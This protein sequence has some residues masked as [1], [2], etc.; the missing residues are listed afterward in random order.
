MRREINWPENP[1][2][3]KSYMHNQDILLSDGSIQFALFIKSKS[4]RTWHN[5]F[6]S[7]TAFLG[8]GQHIFPTQHT[9]DM[10]K[11]LCWTNSLLFVNNEETLGENYDDWLSALWIAILTLLNAIYIKAYFFGLSTPELCLKTM[12]DKI[13]IIFYLIGPDVLQL[14][15]NIYCIN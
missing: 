6:D 13:K 4:P 8:K 10:K 9:L 1:K 7:V 5:F 3:S 14:E 12:Q 15:T 11:I 2:D